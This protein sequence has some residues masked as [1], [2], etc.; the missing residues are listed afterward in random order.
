MTGATAVRNATTMKVPKILMRMYPPQCDRY[1]IS[2]LPAR[3]G[4]ILHRLMKIMG[5]TVPAQPWPTWISSAR[6]LHHE[7]AN[8]DQLVG[9]DA[10][11][12]SVRVRP[13]G[14][15]PV[16]R[17]ARSHRRSGLA[18]AALGGKNGGPARVLL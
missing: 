13:E 5:D 6:R 16:Q 15:R 14:D 4:Q 1:A 3:G 7:T 8:C 9:G 12:R 11:R 2:R 17:E 10:S 18:E